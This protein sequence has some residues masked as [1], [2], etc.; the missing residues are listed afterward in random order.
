LPGS[1]PRR[2]AL[3]R[4]WASFAAVDGHDASLGDDA[5]DRAGHIHR[6]GLY[7]SERNRLSRVMAAAGDTDT[8]TAKRELDTFITGVANEHAVDQPYR[9]PEQRQCSVEASA[10]TA[11]W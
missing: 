2:H 4:L 10:W 8:S 7:V 9:E 11:S 6:H 3:E 1:R 5:T